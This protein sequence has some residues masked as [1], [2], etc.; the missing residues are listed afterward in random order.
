MLEA[1]K[2]SYVSQIAILIHSLNFKFLK[3][4]LISGNL[5]ITEDLMRWCQYPLMDMVEESVYRF[6]LSLRLVASSFIFVP[7]NFSYPFVKMGKPHLRRNSY[8]SYFTMLTR[9][10]TSIVWRSRWK[11]STETLIDI[12]IFK[13]MNSTLNFIFSNN[14]IIS[15]RNALFCITLFTLRNDWL[16]IR[17]FK[18]WTFHNWNLVTSQWWKRTSWFTPLMYTN[19][20]L[21]I[22]AFNF[23]VFISSESLVSLLFFITTIAFINFLLTWYC[24]FL[25]CCCW[26]SATLNLPFL[27]HFWFGSLTLSRIIFRLTRLHRPF[28]AILINSLKFQPI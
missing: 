14:I 11:C 18:L 26:A 3:N 4:S 17:I 6:L 2:T 25:S 7:S 20:A 5:I 28:W 13:L 10:L 1:W 27:R 12:H 15:W 24:Y 22:T 8:S 9:L 19:A 16:F 23:Y 21:V